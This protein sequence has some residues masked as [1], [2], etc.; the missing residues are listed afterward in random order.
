MDGDK[1][2]NAGVH[3]QQVQDQPSEGAMATCLVSKRTSL[4]AGL[5][6]QAL[7]NVHPSAMSC[8]GDDE[9]RLRVA[10]AIRKLARRIRACPDGKFQPST[11]PQLLDKLTDELLI[12]ALEAVVTVSA[13][14]PALTANATLRLLAWT[15]AD[16]RGATQPLGK[17]L[18]L[19]VGKR[20]DRQAR[21]VRTVLSA[22]LE[23][24]QHDRQDLQG[25]TP[26]LVEAAR[27]EIDAR[28]RTA[29]EAARNEVYI[30]FHELLP[31]LPGATAAAVTMAAV[32]ADADA[33]DDDAEDAAAHTPMN[34]SA[35]LAECRYACSSRICERRAVAS[36]GSSSRTS[37]K[38]ERN[39]MPPDL[40]KALGPD[41]AQR[42]RDTVDNPQMNGEQWWSIGLPNYVRGL[43]HTEQVDR[44]Y[45]EGM[46]S[47]EYKETHR[48]KCEAAAAEAQLEEAEETIEELR[49]QLREAKGREDALHE[50]IHRCRWE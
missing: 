31:L 42:M 40:A 9:R 35:S 17:T 36:R 4:L 1:V 6:F 33:D 8:T 38:P 2:M 25:G 15:V 43:L 29:V 19:T 48:A 3:G 26:A 50:D 24:A 21:S 12:I 27:A 18:A 46:L 45:Y 28:V 13:E 20:L 32:A 16:A 41:A 10:E 44:E 23:R 14:E 39:T 30:G 47:D 7:R 5:R 11:P 34:A 49:G 22:T 37:I